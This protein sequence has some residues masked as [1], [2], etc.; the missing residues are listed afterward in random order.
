MLV[1][2]AQRLDGSGSDRTAKEWVEK[3]RHRPQHQFATRFPP[4][5][6]QTTDRWLDQLTESVNQ[7]QLGQLTDK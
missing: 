2:G 5:S 1:K 3:H 4:D 6:G 7:G